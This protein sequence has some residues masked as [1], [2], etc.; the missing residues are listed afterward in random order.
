LA[1]LIDSN[2]WG[3]VYILESLAAYDTSDSKESENIIE[4]VMA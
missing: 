3:K 4:R 2:E 1:A